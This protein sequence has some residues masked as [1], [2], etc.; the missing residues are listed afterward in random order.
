[1]HVHNMLISKVRLLISIALD[2]VLD[3]AMSS[4]ELSTSTPN[5]ILLELL[6]LL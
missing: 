3:S 4:P 6:F 2:T 1:M 5:V